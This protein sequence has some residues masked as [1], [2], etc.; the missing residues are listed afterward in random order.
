MQIVNYIPFAGPGTTA[1][2]AATAAASAL[3]TSEASTANA[4]AI[5][6]PITQLTR[7]AATIAETID[8]GYVSDVSEDD[9]YEA[10]FDRYDSVFASSAYN[11]SA[12]N[13]HSGSNRLSVSTGSLSSL[14]SSM[15]SSSS[16]SSSSGTTAPLSTA[17]VSPQCKPL[18]K[19]HY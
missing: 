11:M 7:C 17:S 12:S 5:T 16:S 18:C 15:H 2:T 8:S 19:C 1:T 14:D 3:N 13:Q 9:S 10:Q 4:A 6:E